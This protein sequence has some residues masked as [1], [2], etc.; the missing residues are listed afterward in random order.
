MVLFCWMIFL[1][2]VDRSKYFGAF[3]YIIYVFV[4]SA[5]CCL[6]CLIK[7]EYMVM[8]YFRKRFSMF[9]PSCTVQKP[10]FWTRLPSPW[11]WCL[12]QWNG[13]ISWGGKTFFIST[14]WERRWGSYCLVWRNEYRFQRKSDDSLQFEFLIRLKLIRLYFGI[15]CGLSMFFFMLG[16]QSRNTILKHSSTKDSSVFRQHAWAKRRNPKMNACALII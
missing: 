2:M 8:L 14:L 6:Y 7:L 13:I 5:P 4:W 12:D 3:K 9:S 16:K 15:V 1:K 10:R 11:T